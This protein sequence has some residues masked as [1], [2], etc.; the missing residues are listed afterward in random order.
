MLYRVVTRAEES[1][2]DEITSILEMEVIELD[3]AKWA[4]LTVLALENDSA[5]R[6]CEDYHKPNAVT[7]LDSDSIKQVNGCLGGLRDTAI[8]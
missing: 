6:L 5:L 4:S 7:V 1:K 3:Q 8:F 2:K